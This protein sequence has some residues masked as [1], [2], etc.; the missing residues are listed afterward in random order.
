MKRFQSLSSGLLLLLGLASAHAQVSVTKT[1]EGVNKF[2]PDGFATGVAD[3]RT[4]EATGIASITDLEVRLTIAGGYNGDLYCYLVHDSGFVVLLNRPG[5]SCAQPRGYKD[6]GF[7]ACFSTK[8]TKDFHTY[9]E[10]APV[11]PVLP[12]VWAPDARACDPA[13]TLDTAARTKDFSS[14]AGVNPNGKWT[15]FVA[16][17]SSGGQAKLKDWGL[18]IT[19]TPENT[20]DLRLAKAN[21]LVSVQP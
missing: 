6:A 2:I 8:A 16:D 19:G 21:S 18:V 9:R 20:P 10:Q 7:S 17:V 15:L 4:I 11:G 3:T 5:R 1:F 14:F 12:G 13:R